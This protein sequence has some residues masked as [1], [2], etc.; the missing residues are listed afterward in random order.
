MDGAT[1]YDELVAP[2]V[3]TSTL[4]ALAV[5]VARRRAGYAVTTVAL[6]AVMALTVA[7]AIGDTAIFGVDSA[8]TRATGAGHELAVTYGA[9]TRP[10]IATPFDVEVR[11]PGGFD[12]AVRVAVDRSYLRMWDENGLVPAPASETV[13]GDRVV[14]EFDPPSGDTLAVSYDGRIEPAA[15]N[16]RNGSVAVL[17]GDEAV[18]VEVTFTTRVWP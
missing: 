1:R 12:D 11:R 8:T 4:P 17:D 2:D 13:V 6:T 16:G 5:S 7:D 3:P 10:A 14:W 9:V 18:L 15:Q